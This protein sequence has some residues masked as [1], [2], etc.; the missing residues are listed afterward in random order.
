MQ[1]ESD[2]ALA[3]S[4]WEARAFTQGDVAFLTLNPFRGIC[5]VGD[6]VSAGLGGVQTGSEL[7]FR[8]KPLGVWL[9]FSCLSFLAVKWGMLTVLITKAVVRFR[10][11]PAYK[12]LNRT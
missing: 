1:R 9:N 12:V 5:H 6:G 3:R 8:L 2:M 7:V 4:G 10:T 11:V